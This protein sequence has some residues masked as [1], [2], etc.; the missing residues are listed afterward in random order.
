MFNFKKSSSNK[1]IGAFDQVV[2]SM[3]QRGYKI[4]L[5]GDLY[6]ADNGDIT[7]YFQPK[8]LVLAF[9]L[10]KPFSDRIRERI[11]DEVGAFMH[12]MNTGNSMCDIVSVV[13]FNELLV[14]KSHLRLDQTPCPFEAFERQFVDEAYEILQLLEG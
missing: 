3:K 11:N 2:E 12:D 7:F 5:D 6:N 14:F 13:Y 10:L 1:D 9:T 4:A 8:G